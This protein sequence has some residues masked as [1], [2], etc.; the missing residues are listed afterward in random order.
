[1]AE[2]LREGL[3]PA[4]ALETTAPEAVVAALEGIVRTAEEEPEERERLRAPTLWILEAGRWPAFLTRIADTPL[5]DRWLEA[6]LEAIR[7]YAL[8]FGDLFRLRVSQ[9]PERIQVVVP[10]GSGER[11]I[12]RRTLGEDVAAAAAGIRSLLP[13]P[14]GRVQLALFT[15]NR[16]EGMVTDLASL[17]EGIVN[18]PIP[19]DATP[20]HV[21]AILAATEPAV[22]VVS[23][24]ARLDGLLSGGSLPGVRTIVLIDPPEREEGP[25]EAAPLLFSDLLAR[26]RKDPIR[27]PAR[28]DPEAVATVM[29]TSG[30]TGRPK[31]IRFCQRNIVYKRFCR[32]VALP[33]IGED[34]RFLCYLPLFHTFGRYLEMTGSLYWGA[35]YLFMGNPSKEAMLRSMARYGPTVLI[36]IPKRWIQLHE[37]ILQTLG[38]EVENLDDVDPDRLRGAVREVT[39][40]SLRWGLS[41]AGHL[42]PDLFQFFQR[43]GVELMSGFGMTEATGGI[44]MTPP[45]RYKRGTVGAPLPG[46]ELRLAEDGELLVRGPYMMLGY[47]DEP[48]VDLREEWFAT[49]DI[50]QVDRDGYYTIVDRKKDIYKNVKGQT[51]APQKIENLFNE[52]EEIKRVFLVGDGREYNT[53]LVY[54][55]YEASDG[56][57]SKMSD[58]D[59]RDYISS[60]VVSVNRFLSP[61]ERVVNFDLLP[62]FFRE[63]RGELTPK[64]TFVRKV[65]ERNFA[66]RIDALYARPYVT[67][68]VGAID[69]R[70]PSWL[71]R[72]KGVT[73]DDLIGEAGGIR[74]RHTGERLKINR[75][76]NRPGL[77]RIG[78]LLYQIES[79]YPGAS[80]PSVVDL[81][82]LLRVPAYW[83][84]NVEL[85]HFAGEEL[86][87]RPRRGELPAQ[88]ITIHGWFRPTL[89]AGGSRIRLLA[90]Q[91]RSDGGPSAVHA[92]IG[93]LLLSHDGEAAERFEILERFLT[94]PAGETAHLTL[95][96][97]PLLR[98]HPDGDVRRRA[99]ALL[100]PHEPDDL[101][102]ETLRRFLAA[103]AA[104]LDESVRARLLEADLS[105]AAIRSILETARDFEPI[106][107]AVEPALT[108][109]RI[110]SLL[111]FAGEIGSGRPSW[112]ASAR[113][114][115]VLRAA[116]TPDAAVAACAREERTRLDRALRQWIAGRTPPADAREPGAPTPFERIVAFDDRVEGDVRTRLLTALEETTL[117]QESGFLLCEETHLNRADLLPGGIWVSHLGSGHGKTVVRFT[118]RLRNGRVDEF[119]V[120]VLRKIDPREAEAEADWM[121]RLGTRE[122][123]VR[124]VPEFG[125]FWPEHGV[126]SEEFLSNDT[127]L[128]YLKRLTRNPTPERNQRVL[129]VWPHLAWSALATFVE[130]WHRSGRKVVLAEPVPFNIVVA[131]HDYQEGSRLVSVSARTAFDGLAEMIRSSYEGFVDSTEA[132]FPILR[133]IVPRRIA[134]AAMLEALGEEDGIPLLWR[135]LAEMREKLEAGDADPAWS[136]WHKELGR[137]LDEVERDGYAP[138]RLVMAVRRYHTWITLNAGASAHARA[139]TLQEI[140]ETYTLPGLEAQHPE[141]RIRFFRMTVFS[142]AR[143]RIAEE[144]DTLIR[145]HRDA[146]LGL[147]VLLRRMTILHQ[148]MELTEEESYFLARMTYSHL[149]PAQRVRIELHEEGG[150]T[151]ADLVEEMADDEGGVVRIRSAETPKEVMR[152]HHLF[153]QS[154]LSVVFRPEHQF[155]LGTDEHDVVIGGLFYRPVDREWVH[156][157]KIVVS[158][159]H[160]GR[161]AGDRLMESFLE[162]LRDAHVARVTTGFFR[163]HYFYRFGFK[164]ERGTAGLVKDLRD[165]ATRE[166]AAEL[167]EDR[168]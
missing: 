167:D 99:F 97:L 9:Q 129:A 42:D 106:L 70:V 56:K 52:F 47:D 45:G 75:E 160:R 72:E 124:L 144:L 13:D 120:K 38:E 40:G 98:E 10:R 121:I 6:V 132:A 86:I 105:P 24:A 33:E 32:A 128:A 138:R 104:V 57:L 55:N 3:D 142:D 168:S 84:G 93:A 79:A 19:A 4:P 46:V 157:E 49:G 149:K 114:V 39:G 102:A 137:T 76:G 135:A 136:K 87:R 27:T 143:P 107:D 71:L 80:S 89:A 62:R 119:V 139:V 5:A 2:R 30:T 14:P 133:G 147:D 37:T 22:F 25:S 63:D 164:L 112:Y 140:Y 17:T 125:G 61:F 20:E 77:F 1:M 154:G 153:E 36:S 152:L 41:A 115:L 35:T 118:V 85:A 31:G 94:N 18:V 51:I 44:T 111:R 145:D 81:D 16:Y 158:P 83:V 8:S 165:P 166:P 156:M 11:K 90:V 69:V 151:T 26:G 48:P 21:R 82:P 73:T 155:L 15:P 88:K 110:L 64:G 126:W 141:I 28:V 103:D 67:V 123:A 113:Q 23:D 122:R 109:Q 134:F 163:P 65:V 92:A 117:L 53:L 116:T 54:P 68:R 91:Q 131:P 78:N 50:F 34:D 29:F 59:L 96:F 127:V 150:E 66:D 161:G 148:A 95:E 12:S 108:R 7:V 58:V 146:P 100:L 43:F 162:R 159:R 130:F 101:V 74:L 60:Y